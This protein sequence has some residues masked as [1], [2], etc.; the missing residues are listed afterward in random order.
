MKVPLTTIEI[1][2]EKK[3]IYNGGEIGYGGENRI[4]R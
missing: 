3:D 2:S 4:E 1:G